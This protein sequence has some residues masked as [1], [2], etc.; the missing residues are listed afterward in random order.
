M[1]N[2]IV[3][4]GSFFRGRGLRIICLAMVNRN[5]LSIFSNSGNGMM[6]LNE[7]RRGGRER[8][9]EQRGEGAR[10]HNIRG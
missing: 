6:S 4:A 10:R 1:C 9:E 5:Y 3:S 7:G 8:K 2:P